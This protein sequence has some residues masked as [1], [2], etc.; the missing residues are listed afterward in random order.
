MLYF[1]CVFHIRNADEP[2]PRIPHPPHPTRDDDDRPTYPTIQPAFFFTMPAKDKSNNSSS[3]SHSTLHPTPLPAQPIP[4]LLH[5]NALSASGVALCRVVVVVAAFLLATRKKSN[6]NNCQSLPL[7]TPVTSIAQTACPLASNSTHLTHSLPPSLSLSRSQQLTS[8][9]AS[10]TQKPTPPQSHS[11]EHTLTITSLLRLC[12]ASQT[13]H[14]TRH[15]AVCQLICRR[16]PLWPRL[17]PILLTPYSYRPAARP[18][19][20]A[21][22]RVRVGSLTPPTSASPLPLPLPLSA[23]LCFCTHIPRPVLPAASSLLLLLFAHCPLPHI[24]L[25]TFCHLPSTRTFRVLHVLFGGVPH[26]PNE[27]AHVTCSR[28]RSLRECVCA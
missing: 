12:S 8:H 25:H 20:C 13:I 9:S 4:A 10:P 21:R 1:L 15:S 3:N 14:K 23:F 26:I 11:N 19:A 22:T 7:P 27:R 6:K 17:I 18:A 24:V 5:R 2:T 28:S 16:H